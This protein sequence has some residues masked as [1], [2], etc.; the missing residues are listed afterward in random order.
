MWQNVARIAGNPKVLGILGK[1][2][3][4]IR[5]PAFMPAAG[6][7][8]GG[9][10]GGMD[11]GLGGAL[12]GAGAGAGTGFLLRAGANKLP[13]AMLPIGATKVLGTAVP[14]AGG[15]IAGATAVP[16]G[17]VAGDAAGKVA[18]TGVI[19]QQNEP[20]VGGG[21][22]GGP[23]SGSGGGYGGGGQG[24][25]PVLG[26]DH[27]RMVQGPDGSIWQE[28]DPTGW[29]QGMRAGS[30]LDTQQNISN[31]N[32]WFKSRFPQS[33]MVKKADF[34]RELAA[35]QLGE[36]IKMARTMMEGTHEGN[37]NIAEQAGR[38]M[39]TLLNSRYQYF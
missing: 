27:G 25:V 17:N 24:P 39:G 21:Y 36:N 12:R 33:E 11:D 5:N 16:T 20:N 19:M 1:L 7:T 22:I 9:I 38:D 6:A 35:L 37:V 30:G 26:G 4:V 2:G 3:N 13:P 15:V 31:A 14:L 10:K 8:I 28:I 23:G 34:E 18:G 29:K 32:R